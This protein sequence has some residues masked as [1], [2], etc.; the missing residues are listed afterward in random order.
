MPEMVRI[1][2][3]KPEPAP[4]SR[5]CSSTSM[6]N[7]LVVLAMGVHLRDPGAGTGTAFAA[8]GFAVHTGDGRPNQFPGQ[9]PLAAQAT[10]H[11]VVDALVAA[12]RRL[13]LALPQH[14]GAG[15]GWPAC[16]GLRCSRAA[17]CRQTNHPA[18]AEAA[19]TVGLEALKVMNTSV[20]NEAARRACFRR[21]TA[22][23]RT[24]RRHHTTR[25]CSRPLLH[26]FAQQ[27]FRNTDAPWGC[28][29]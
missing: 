24:P 6:K 19:G 18:R 27:A 9:I 11:E 1:G 15:S 12:Q 4:P 20:D 17:A 23:C 14:V 26:D 16:S 29:G 5:A 13:D 3:R 25:L 7:W 2:A 22:P 8:W 21:R 10:F 28:W